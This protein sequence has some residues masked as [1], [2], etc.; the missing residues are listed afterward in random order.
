MFE[1]NDHVCARQ[2]MAKKAQNITVN[3]VISSE[4]TGMNRKNDSQ[5]L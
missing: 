4:K 1:D 3:N 2:E 5:P